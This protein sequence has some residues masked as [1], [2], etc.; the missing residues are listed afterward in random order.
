MKQV[1][2]VKDFEEICELFYPELQGLLGSTLLQKA[3]APMLTSTTA[4][5]QAFYGPALMLGISNQANVFGALPK[6]PWDKSGFRYV[7]ARA[8]ANAVGIAEGGAL[9]DTLK[10]TVALTEPTAKTSLVTF[11]LSEVMELKAAKGEDVIKWADIVEYMAGEFAYALD[12]DLSTDNDVLGGNNLESIDRIAGSYSEITNCD[13]H[14]GAA[15]T[16]G[17]LDVYGKDRDAGATAYDAY[18]G[19]AGVAGTETD[20][21]LT[22]ALINA[23]F[24][25]CAPYWDSYDR[26][27][28][29]TTYETLERWT[30]LIDPQARYPME[31]GLVRTGVGGVQTVPGKELGVAMSIYRGVPV[32][33]DDL[34][35][36]DTIGTISLFDLEYLSLQVLKPVT[37]LDSGGN[38][39]F[40]Q[41]VAREGAHELIAELYSNRFPV[42]G[43]LRGLK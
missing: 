39:M 10:P 17:D 29:L 19:H 40:M 4:F 27:V 38:Y 31:G 25:N 35:S 3:D 37:L 11:D 42:H 34:I 12:N 2:S 22:I 16:A 13:D 23:L 14:S 15:Y 33:P 20:R 8:K 1:V 6:V 18:V 21:T 24:Q 32:I 26:K 28:F 41:K 36:K 9:P 7:T 5:A 43:K 30:E